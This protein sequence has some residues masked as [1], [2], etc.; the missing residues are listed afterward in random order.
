MKSSRRVLDD[1]V[2]E[3]GPNPIAIGGDELHVLISGGAAFLGQL[4]RIARGCSQAGGNQSLAEL[5]SMHV[6]NRPDRHVG[7]GYAR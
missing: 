3:V 4:K 7:G 2:L 1:R 5:H 6:N